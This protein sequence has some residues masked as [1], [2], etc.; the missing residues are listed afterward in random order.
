MYVNLASKELQAVLDATEPDPTSLP[1]LAAPSKIKA[2][3]AC[4][5][6]FWSYGWV[7]DYPDGDNIM[8]LLYGGNI[9]QSNVA[10]YA[11]SAFDSLYEKSKSMPDSPERTRL[12]EQMTRQFEFDA[13]WR[14]R[15]A[16]YK[17]M[18]MQ[19]RVIGY[20]AHPVL[21]GEWIYTDLDTK[22]R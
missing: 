5:H 12:F 8:Q 17:N 15:V 19:S 11:S 18:L 14:L 3:I 21:L 16:P 7:A 9:N 1:P 4:R 10:C 6:Q 22:A 2:A 20:K 13:P